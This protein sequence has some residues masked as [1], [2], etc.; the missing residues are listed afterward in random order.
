MIGKRVGKYRIEELLGIGGMGEVFRAWDRERQV[1]VA[2]K[3][4]PPEAAVDDALRRRFRREAEAAAKLDHPAIV[5]FVELL[6]AD[7]GCWLVMEY[8]E[9]TSLADLIEYHGALTPERV[10]V[11]ARQIVEGLQAAHEK[12]I[13]HRDLKTENVLV[14]H[15]GRARILDFGLA[16][17]LFREESGVTLTQEGTMVGTCRAMSPEQ[18][19][20]EPIDQRSDL[21]SLG[22]LL[23]EALTGTSPFTAATPLETVALVVSRPHPP[24]RGR[25]PRI[26]QGLADLV[27]ALLQKDPEDRP[28][29]AREVLRLLDD[30]QPPGSWS[31]GLARLREAPQV[32][33]Y[34]A[35][36]LATAGGAYFLSRAAPGRRATS[37]PATEAV[38]VPAGRRLTPV[39]PP[40]RALSP[41]MRVLVEIA[42]E[43]F[44]SGRFARAAQGYGDVL[45]LA[46][47]RPD[48]LLALADAK[49]VL[50]DTEAAGELYARVLELS[51]EPAAWQDRA[52]RARALAQSG[53]GAD[54]VETAHE[55]WL[56]A[57]GNPWAAYE[58]AV[59]FA[60]A[61]DLEAALDAAEEA[62]AGGV[63]HR[64]LEAPWLE[65]L[66]DKLELV[67]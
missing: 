65:A 57:P 41:A 56:L 14:D 11:L 44:L 52:I 20:G 31:S 55:A 6:E 35:I 27:E 7:A 3:R 2:L 45:E 58:A 5:H 51:T 34:L 61:G 66:Q 49:L 13:I 8:V 10:L 23:Y 25:N 39:P 15:A 21:F 38:E 54:A 28:Q 30:L 53:N 47:D 40:D 46:P 12:E 67:P 17:H 62:L 59:A 16:K 4:L 48:L 50:G 63:E 33:L 32:F 29:S 22:I 37:E 18:A 24:L 60:I 9:G 43:D 26:P 36:G 42:L 64:W 19:L 1:Q